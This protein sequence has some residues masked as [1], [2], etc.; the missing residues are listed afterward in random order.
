V[1]D[2]NNKLPLPALIK[3]RL[4]F[5]IAFSMLGLVAFL[6]LIPNPP[7][8]GVNDK[9]LHFSSYAGL[10]AGFSTL[11]RNHRQLSGVA[12]GLIGYGIVIE[13]LQGLTGYRFMEALDVVANSAGAMT[14]LLVW[15]T[16]LPGWFRR[17]EARLF[18]V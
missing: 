16:P 5:G 17:F 12:I 2:L 13:I 10:S 14:G 1:V 18:R 9:L 11:V 6:S 15:L 8:A 3:P 4:W 7:A